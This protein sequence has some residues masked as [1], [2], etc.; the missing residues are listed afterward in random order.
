[1]TLQADNYLFI[2]EKTAN[3]DKKKF[4]TKHARIVSK[5]KMPTRTTHWHSRTSGAVEQTK[6]IKVPTSKTK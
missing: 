4:L 6:R 3:K 5:L 1:M 2:I